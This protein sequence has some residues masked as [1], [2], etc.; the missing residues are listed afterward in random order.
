MGDIRVRFYQK[1]AKN[2][3]VLAQQWNTLNG[4]I[5]L[6]PFNFWNVEA[7]ACEST[8]PS[9]Q[10][11]KRDQGCGRL[12]K[13]LI[14][15]SPIVHIDK[16]ES[17]TDYELED[18]LW[19]RIRKQ[20]NKVLRLRYIWFI[21]LMVATY[22]LMLP[23]TAECAIIPLIGGS[24][25]KFESQSGAIA[26]FALV[27]T[28][29]LYNLITGLIWLRYKPTVSLILFAVAGAMTIVICKTGQ[30]VPREYAN[31]KLGYF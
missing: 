20:K 5:S 10:Q 9:P 25:L 31:F 28:I 11:L 15:G 14:G 30:S 24:L 1:T 26:L 13:K 7:H 4:V 12:L 23:F 21:W 19:C 17:G 27:S 2:A 3:T 18:L 6:R 16:A 29:G 22:L 8:M